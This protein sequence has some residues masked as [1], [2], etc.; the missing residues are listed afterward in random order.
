MLRPRLTVIYPTNNDMW[1][2]HFVLLPVLNGLS[3]R[4]SVLHHVYNTNNVLNRD[5]Q[6]T[7]MCIL[8]VGCGTWGKC[9]ALQLEL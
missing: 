9:S 6:N 2:L 4:V 7:I 8:A 3:S 5:I 1:K